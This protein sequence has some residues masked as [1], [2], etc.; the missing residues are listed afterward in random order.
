MAKLADTQTATMLDQALDHHRAGRIVEA[1]EGYHRI[2]AIDPGHADSLHLLG[3]IA[4]EAGDCDTAVS[5]IRRAI[6][7]NPK[8]SS[9]H[10]NLG[11]VLQHLGLARD[12]GSCYLNALR[13]K[14]DLVEAHVNLAHV[15]LFAENAANA[16]EWYEKA[17]ALRPDLPEVHKKIGDAHR[18]QGAQERAVAAYRRAVA[19]RP[20]YADA[21]HELGGLLR[22]ERDLA[23]AL[24]CFR[25]AQASEPDHPRAGFAEALV[26]LLQGNFRAGWAAYECRW[27]SIDHATPMRLYLQPAWQ[28]QSIDGAL[29]LWPEQGVGDEIMFSALLPDVVRTGMRCILECDPRLQPLFARSFPQVEVISDREAAHDPARGIAAQLPIGSLPSFYRNHRTEFSSAIS[30]Y[31]LADPGR[32]EHYRSRYA[33]ARK[34][35]GL[36]W[37]SD[38]VK[39]GKDRSID[40]PILKPLFA[41]SELR[42]VSLQYGEH[43]WLNEQI[44]AAGVPVFLD[45]EV[46]QLQSLDEFAAQVAAMDLVVTIDNTTAHLAGALGVPVWLLLPFAPDW[47]WPHATDGRSPWYPSMRIFQQPTRGHWGS[48]VTQVFEALRTL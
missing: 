42:W 33:D 48:V 9:Y 47:R 21:L 45:P 18:M 30:P 25:E 2:L 24:A 20:G 27:K 26:L 17:L 43:E 1:E 6:E 39:T 37:Y 7:L 13:I 32:R 5:K 23:G 4:Y 36:A 15:F 8:A 40:L 34:A 12:A 46:D 10:L 35:V 11:N 31:L 41:A 14:P 22:A 38:N 16:I 19:L 29:L 28:G 44:T 3:M